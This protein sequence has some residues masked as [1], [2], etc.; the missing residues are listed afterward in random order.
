MILTTLPAIDG[1]SSNS[2]CRKLQH[3]DVTFP[4][5]LVNDGNTT[6]AR[7]KGVVGRN[8][9]MAEMRGGRRP[10]TVTAPPIA[11]GSVH[12]HYRVEEG[13]SS[14]VEER[15]GRVGDGGNDSYKGEVR[16]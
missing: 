13:V 12:E 5:L 4:A 16:M 1:A 9:H 15:L 8:H 10:W 11:G 2:Q 7:G 3:V 6:I 14:R